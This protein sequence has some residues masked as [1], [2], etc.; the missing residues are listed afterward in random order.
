LSKVV[1]VGIDVFDISLGR[2]REVGTPD[3]GLLSAR[4]HMSNLRILE[5]RHSGGPEV[6][7]RIATLLEK[8]LPMWTAIRPES[9]AN[10][11]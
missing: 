8:H 11:S 2:V 7:T 10:M 4:A 6:P 1:L 3:L 5:G 9:E